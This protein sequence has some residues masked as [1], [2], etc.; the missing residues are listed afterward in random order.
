MNPQT[1]NIVSAFFGVLLGMLVGFITS[2]LNRKSEERKHYRQ[3]IINAAV[4]NFKHLSRDPKPG[5]TYLPLDDHIL[6]MMKFTE[7]MIDQRVDGSNLERKLEEVGAFAD[8]LVA[9]R[10]KE[11]KEDRP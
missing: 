3:L 1:I 5:D 8:R 6:H 2:T 7:V 11:L 4:E 10:I 9:F